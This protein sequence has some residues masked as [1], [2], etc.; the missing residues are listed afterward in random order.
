MIKVVVRVDV[1]PELLQWA[2]RRSGWDE[3]TASRRTPQLSDWLHKKERPTLK[4]LKKFANDTHTPFG[5]FFLPEPPEENVPIPD[6]RTMGN[7]GIHQPSA[8]LLDTLYLCQRRQE[9]Y[10]EYALLNGFDEISFVGTV[11]VDTPIVSAAEQIRDTLGFNL[12]ERTAFANWEQA[13][14]QLIDLIENIGVLVMVNGVVGSNTHRKLEPSEFRGF[15]LADPL[16]PLIFVNGADTKA[17]QI[18]T[19]VHE[20]AH[21]WL[22]GSALSD[23]AMTATGGPEEERWCNQVA[24]EVLV[25]LDFLVKEH[26]GDVDIN[27]LERLAKR[28]RVSTLVVLKRLYDADFLTWNEYL[29]EY[30]KEKQRVMDL[31]ASKRGDKNGGNYYYTQPLRLSHNFSRA[32]ISSAFEGSTSY[33]EAYQLLGTKKHA[34]FENLAEKLGIA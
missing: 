5:L 22:G 12:S 3:E 1:A 16:V 19:L 9:W 14:R 13:L 26:R 8:D 2:I 10:R 4:Q 32:V 6:M 28:F 34:T 31:L 33:R 7:L 21:I 20:L 25:P 23:A 11:T 24:A 29:Q 17:A 18:F 30:K 27:E 15:A